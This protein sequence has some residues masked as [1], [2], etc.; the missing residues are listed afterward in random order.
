MRDD[1]ERAAAV[2]D[3]A[4]AGA[5]SGTT[6]GAAPGHVQCNVV[7]LPAGDAEA[8]TAWCE[9]NPSVAPLLA[10]S[11]PGD[12]RLPAL[13]EIDLRTDLPAYRR[14]ADGGFVEELDDLGEWWTDDLVGMAF[15]CSF[16]LEEALADAGVDLAY[17]RR[18]FGGA[19]FVT[20]IETEPHGDYGGPTVV[21][22]RP[23]AP[24]DAQL[25]VEVS[26]RYPQ[27]HGQPVHVGDPA[28]IGVDL[29]RPL[30]RLGDVDVAQ[31]EVPVFW[32]CGVTTQLALERARPARAFTHVS[33]RMLVCDLRIDELA[34][35]S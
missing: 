26:R 33:A 29:A 28:Q 14:F 20:T 2:R 27:L 11:E 6:R 22:M 15:G 3:A 18:G 25:A 5:W 1:L 19:T 8:F 13:G 12:P 17:A 30:D 34:V 35:A 21:S 32:A 23:L 10:R 31:G 24:D 7:I 9:R 4:R 16:S